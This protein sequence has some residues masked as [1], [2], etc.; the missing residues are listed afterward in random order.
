MAGTLRLA[1]VVFGGCLLATGCKATTRGALVPP[2]GAS[3]W[4]AHLQPAFDD[5]MTTTPVRLTGRAP[6]DVKDQRLFGVR[7][8]CADIVLLAGIDHVWDRRLHQGRPVQQVDLTL[9]DVLL[10]YLDKKVSADQTFRVEVTDPLAGEL[11]ESEVM[12]FLRWAPGE[13]PE[14]HHHLMLADPELLAG[15][16][17][18]IRHAEQA[19]KLPK[20]PKQ[21]RKRKR[22]RKSK[23]SSTGARCGYDEVK[24][25]LQA[26]AIVESEPEPEPEKATPGAKDTSKRNAESAKAKADGPKAKDGL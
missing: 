15:V 25:I 13:Q 17:A 23:A 3:E 11:Q 6:N 10:G 9:G 4:E 2:A 1:G 12:V 8:G 14:Y 24:D 16:Q 19:G 18:Q 22:K 21:R 26:Q 20:K 5:G 7:L